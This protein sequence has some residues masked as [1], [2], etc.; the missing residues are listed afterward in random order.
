MGVPVERLGAVGATLIALAATSSPLYAADPELVEIEAEVVCSAGE[1]FDG[2]PPWPPG[3]PVPTSRC[4]TFNVKCGTTGLG[5][6]L[7]AIAE[8]RRTRP[9]GGITEGSVVFISGGAGGAFYGTKTGTRS[10][11]GTKKFARDLIMQPLILAGYQIIEF[12]WIGEGGWMESDVGNNGDPYNQAAWL[13]LREAA[14]RP[15][16]L[17]QKLREAWHDPPAGALPYCATG[18]S[19]GAVQ[20]AYAMT[21]QAADTFLDSVVLTSGPPFV[22]QVFG[23]REDGVCGAPQSSQFGCYDENKECL[24]DQAYGNPHPNCLPDPNTGELEGSVGMCEEPDDSDPAWVDF[25]EDDGLVPPVED[26]L[27]HDYDYP[28]AVH[29][30]FGQLDVGEAPAQGMKYRNRLASSSATPTSCEAFLNVKHGIPWGS[31]S[32]DPDLIGPANILERIEAFCVP[33]PPPI[34][35]EDIVEDDGCTTGLPVVP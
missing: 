9:D 8:V 28:F 12:K 19:G 14:C 6:A 18:Q 30:L 26:P 20:L 16:V 23:C 4:W 31:E 27:I 34:P 32:E 10:S 25:A 21:Y 35:F 33:N 29:F 1:L 24:L 22:D 3:V 2:N 11:A 5:T 17:L 13:G 7:S 15:A